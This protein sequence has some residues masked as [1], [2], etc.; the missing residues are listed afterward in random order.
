[1][2]TLSFTPLWAEAVRSARGQMTVGIY[3]TSGMNNNL[4]RRG[5]TLLSDMGY[6]GT[7]LT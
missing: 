2:N 7:Q 1:M 3:G 5:I 6:T 4:Q